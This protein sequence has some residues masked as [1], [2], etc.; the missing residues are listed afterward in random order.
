MSPDHTTAPVMTLTDVTSQGNATDSM[1]LPLV[2]GL[3]VGL[4]LATLAITGVVVAVV[5]CHSR[6]GKLESMAPRADPPKDV[7]DYPP[8]ATS[9]PP[10]ASS[11]PPVATS[12]PPAA[13]SYPPAPT[14]HIYE[15]YQAAGG[16]PRVAT[17]LH[18]PGNASG[19]HR[20]PFV[21]RQAPRQVDPG[22]TGIYANV[23]STFP[24]RT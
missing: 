2:L 6:S 1:P 24:S 16:S 17:A 7:Q 21:G 19:G 5:W 4:P 15:N 22:D 3:S 13:T 23:P 10:V 9:Y 11:Y 14:E 12:Y 18:T 8:V 20:S